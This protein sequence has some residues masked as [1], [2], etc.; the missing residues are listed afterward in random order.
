MRVLLVDGVIDLDHGVVIRDAGE[1]RLTPTERELLVY[2]TARAGRDVSR[3]ELHRRV[4]GHADRV[5]SRA[6]TL[7][8]HRLRRKIERDVDAPAHLVTGATGYRWVPAAPDGVSTAPEGVVTLI[9]AQR[10]PPG[11][12]RWLAAAA[13]VARDHAV[14]PIARAPDRALFAADRDDAA[15]ACASAVVAAAGPAEV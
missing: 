4:W 9:V 11:D 14:Y 10:T 5:L 3:D 15:L 1:E 2:L 6:V 7:S 13:A 8:V 12:A